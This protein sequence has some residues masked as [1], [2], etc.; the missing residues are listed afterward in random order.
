MELESTPRML[1]PCEGRQ[2][3][4]RRRDSERFRQRPR[5]EAPLPSG[6]GPFLLLLFCSFLFLGKGSP[7]F[8]EFLGFK[9]D[10]P[11]TGTFFPLGHLASEEEVVQR[12]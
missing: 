3:D 2:E 7:F 10:Q 12:C 5:S 6:G 9:L 4:E 8:I 11:K 1:G